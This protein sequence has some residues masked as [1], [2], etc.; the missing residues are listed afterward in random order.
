MNR[1]KNLQLRFRLHSAVT[2]KQGKW[3]QNF[4]LDHIDA[5]PFFRILH[6]YHDGMYNRQASVLVLYSQPHHRDCLGRH[7]FLQ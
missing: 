4:T 5:I 7:W 2:Q 6:N 3:N 1:I